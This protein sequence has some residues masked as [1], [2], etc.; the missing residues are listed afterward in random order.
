MFI[1]WSPLCVCTSVISSFI[2]CALSGKANVVCGWGDVFD[3]S[4]SAATAVSH[5]ISPICSSIVDF[6]LNDFA[7]TTVISGSYLLPAC[8]I[9]CSRDTLTIF[10]M[11]IDLPLNPVII[12]ISNFW[13]S[14]TSLTKI[15]VVPEISSIWMKNHFFFALW[16]FLI[17]AMMTK[18]QMFSFSLNCEMK[19]Y[20]LINTYSPS[21]GFPETK[22]LNTS[23]SSNNLSIMVV[24]GPGLSVIL[25]LI[26]IIQ[27]NPTF[28]SFHFFARSSMVS[29]FTNNVQRSPKSSKAQAFINHSVDFLLTTEAH[30]LMKSS[31]HWYGQ[32]VCL[33]F[34]I[35]S[36]ISHHNPLMQKNH[37]LISFPI[38]ATWLKDWLIFGDRT[39]IPW[40]CAS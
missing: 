22:T 19:L 34:W 30:L 11:L 35:T 23:Y 16:I 39:E 12:R 27:N 20:F 10:S 17:Y 37:N 1:S 18:F 15:S 28:E 38:A 4:S 2:F 31:N 24:V 13:K 8:L 21:N 36:P 14:S 3:V 26:S 9:N 29:I 5:L 6:N 33:S 7:L 25:V 32:L 40:F